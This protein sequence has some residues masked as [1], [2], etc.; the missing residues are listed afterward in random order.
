VHFRKLNT[1]E[2]C[3]LYRSPSIIRIMKAK[4]LQWT[5]HV[6]RMGRQGSIQNF[7]VKLKNAC[8]EDQARDGRKTLR[9]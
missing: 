5:G 9:C 3:D 6:A 8:L 2:L 1:Q 7:G 4:R